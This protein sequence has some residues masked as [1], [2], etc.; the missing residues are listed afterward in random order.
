MALESAGNRDRNGYI[1]P[2]VNSGETPVT[3]TQATKKLSLSSIVTMEALLFVIALLGIRFTSLALDGADGSIWRY[4]LAGTVAGTI[5]YGLAVLIFRWA[6]AFSASLRELISKVRSSVAHFNLAAILSIAACAAIGEEALFRVF[7][8]SWIDQ[9]APGWAAILIAS[10]LFAAAH[11]ISLA[12]F[13]I[14]LVLG[15]LIGSAFAYTDSIALA[16]SWHFSYDFLSLLVLTR[17]PGVLFLSAHRN[18]SATRTNGH[19]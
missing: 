3:S 8:Q 6:H 12:Y 2:L 5:T 1:I 10:V 19:S 11:A 4:V 7:A 15:L 18:S 17:Y 16:I 9:F 13:A 14:T